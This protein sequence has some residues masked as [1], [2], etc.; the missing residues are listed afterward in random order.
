VVRY[1]SA[2]R[3][4]SIFDGQ[5]AKG[6]FGVGRDFFETQREG[7]SFSKS[8]SPSE[9]RGFFDVVK[10]DDATLKEFTK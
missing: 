8:A 5:T 10:L 1:S 3:R 9:I 7:G 6:S 2:Y 4:S